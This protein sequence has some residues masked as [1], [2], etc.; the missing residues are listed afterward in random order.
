MKRILIVEDEK[1]IALL[2]AT[3]LKTA[4]YETE[5]AHNLTQAFAKIESQDFEKI[6]LDLNLGA[7]YGLDIMPAVRRFQKDC[8]VIVL[9]A[10]HSVSVQKEV[11]D[12]G[13]KQFLKKPFNK[14]E[15]LKAIE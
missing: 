11:H 9:S 2:V 6:F 5:A 10:Y 13:I 4:G 14:A 8:E 3:I 15:L 7:G 12:Q 1:D